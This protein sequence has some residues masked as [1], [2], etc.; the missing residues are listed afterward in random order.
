MHNSLEYA[1]GINSNVDACVQAREGACSHCEIDISDIRH[2]A[3]TTT[4][5][6]N[7]NLLPSNSYFDKTLLH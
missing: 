2:I 1:D 5:L 7:N 6:D 4:L 3:V